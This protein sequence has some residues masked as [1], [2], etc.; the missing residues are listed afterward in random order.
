MALSEAGDRDT[1]SSG[2]QKAQKDTVGTGKHIQQQV[3]F[4]KHANARLQD[5]GGS[6]EKNGCH[7]TAIAQN[8]PNSQRY[9]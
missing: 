7:P 4:D 2:K 8:R 6:W 3:F 9:G 1:D 5:G